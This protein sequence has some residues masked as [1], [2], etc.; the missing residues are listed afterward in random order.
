MLP[1][2]VNHYKNMFLSRGGL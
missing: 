2:G 1:R